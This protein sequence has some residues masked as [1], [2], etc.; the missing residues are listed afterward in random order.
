MEYEQPNTP[1]KASRC[2]NR[3]Y[4]CCRHVVRLHHAQD[5]T[6]AVSLEEVIVTAQKREQ[7]LQ[8]VPVSISSFNA[9]ELENM[10]VTT[11]ID[12]E[13]SVPKAQ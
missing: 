10:G 3:H 1:Q 7:N 4:F 8:E 6:D 2:S 13:K 12:L 5:G 9:V 11:I